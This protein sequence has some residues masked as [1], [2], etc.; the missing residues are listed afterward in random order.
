MRWYASTPGMASRQVAADL[1]VLVWVAVCWIASRA[2]HGAIDAVA[3]PAR[4]A[5][6][7][8][9]DLS[10]TMSDAG[11]TAGEVPVVGDGFAA[12]FG[13]AA[14]AFDR[15]AA[16]AAEQ[17]AAVERAADVVGWVVLLLPVLAVLAFWLP[18]RIR[19]ART[20]AA[21]QRHIDAAA[22]LDLF[23]LRAMATLPMPAIASISPDPV[24]A[25]RE[26]D[27][28]VITR[29]AEVELRRSGMVLPERFRPQQAGTSAAEDA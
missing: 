20:A 15:L 5:M 6:T 24:R 17:V 18:A 14:D 3:G 4:G 19:F 23:A 1:F 2:V 10:S 12:P 27:R 22:D 25:W 16:T 26:G 11:A 28:A 29:L 8:A 21:S 13:S 7:A 9:Q